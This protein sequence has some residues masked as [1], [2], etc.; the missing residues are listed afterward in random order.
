M[1]KA[2][3]TG[4]RRKGTPDVVQKRHEYEAEIAVALAN[5]WTRTSLAA[6]IYDV[7]SA[8]VLP[9]QVKDGGAE[10]VLSKVDCA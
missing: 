6:I 1:A 2:R 7:F 4:R 5:G 3:K 10:P 8:G 9:L